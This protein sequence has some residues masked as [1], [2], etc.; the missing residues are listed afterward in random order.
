MAARAHDFVVRNHHRYVQ[1]ASDAKT[2]IERLHDVFS[3]V[4]HV[5]AVDAIEFL[6]RPGNLHDFHGRRGIRQLVIQAGRKSNGPRRQSLTHQFPHLRNLRAIGRPVQAIHGRHPQRHMPDQQRAIGCRRMG[7][8][9]FDIGSKSRKSEPLAIVI[10]QV[11]R[12]RHGAFHTAGHGRQGNAAVAR[13]HS[14]N[15]L[16]HL[17]RHLAGG[18]HQPIIM[19]VCINEAGRS[20]FP[21]G[22]DFEFGFRLIEPADAHHTLAAHTDVALETRRAAAIDNAGIADQQVEML[23]QFT[24]PFTRS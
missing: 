23:I 4:A 12:R 5:R 6:Q 3:L 24:L 7:T 16:A 15:P 8:E 11:E 21:G 17:R 10:E 13:H 9:L 1:L 2:F 19:R 20:Y 18:Q 14:G 22:V